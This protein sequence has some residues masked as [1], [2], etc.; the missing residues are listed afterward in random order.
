LS[1]ITKLDNRWEID[2]D[3]TIN[4]AQT[5][6]LESKE[7]PMGHTLVVDLSKVTHVDTASISLMFEWLRH[8]KAKKCDL[9]FANFPKNLLSL[10]SLYGVTDLIPQVTH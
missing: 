5:L 7:L 4:Q 3:I 9:R 6:L 1:K 8:A 10:I 2:G